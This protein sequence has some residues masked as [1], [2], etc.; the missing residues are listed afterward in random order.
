M[1]LLVTMNVVQQQN[2]AACYTW[3]S[4]HTDTQISRTATVNRQFI[5]LI[6]S[7]QPYTTLAC[8]PHAVRF[9]SWES[10]QSTLQGYRLTILDDD[11]TVLWHRRLDEDDK[12]AIRPPPAKI[13]QHS[14]EIYTRLLPDG[15]TRRHM[16]AY[17]WRCTFALSS[18]SGEAQSADPGLR[19]ELR[20][21]S[22]CSHLVCTVTDNNKLGRRITQ[23]TN[24][25]RESA[26][27][28]QQLS[29]LI[30]RYN[31]VAVSGRPTFAHTT[32]EQQLF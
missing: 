14:P 10:R 23:S 28:F 12:N 19:S 13:I 25:H 31:A 32:R 2:S 27:L 21:H 4:Q 29:M 5:C 8:T 17:P 20:R 24:D 26:F 9:S 11:H 15:P 16:Q 6:N 3:F 1:A 30:Q 18:V 22:A 7:I